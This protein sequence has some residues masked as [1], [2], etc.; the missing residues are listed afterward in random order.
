MRKINSDAFYGLN[1][2]NIKEELEVLKVLKNKS[3]F[4]YDGIK[5]MYETDKLETKISDMFQREVLCVNNGTSALKLCLLSNNIGYGDEVIVPCLSFISTASCCLSV[6]AIPV[7]CEID[8]TFNIDPRDIEKNINSKTKAIIVVHFQGYPC[9]M[10][11]IIKIAKKYNLVLIEDVAQ[12]FGA[13][14][15]NKLLGTFGDASAFSFQSCKIITCGEGGAVTGN[16]M[17]FIKRYADNGG[18]REKDMMPV[19]NKDFCTYGENFKMTDLQSAILL[20]QFDKLDKI[21]KK[22]KNIFKYITKELS[23]YKLRKCIDDEGC[24]NMSL[25][26][27]F[28]SHN[29]CDKFIEYME[30]NGIPFSKKTSNFLP[31]YNVFLNNKKLSKEKYLFIKNYKVNNCKKSYNL[32]SRSAWLVLN[33]NLSKLDCKYISKKMRN[34]YDK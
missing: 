31:D 32:L 2:I 28:K 18:Y 27:I 13:K 34:Y 23:N 7:M 11:E 1:R 12:A 3:L 24:I 14:Y 4:R 15:N 26:V 6:G 30:K 21:I 29:E 19:W 9:N 10:D 17:P 16:N 8:E 20:K 22:Q 25:C 5:M 33:S